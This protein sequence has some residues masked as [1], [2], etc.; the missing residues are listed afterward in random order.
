MK[1]NY[2]LVLVLNKVVFFNKQELHIPFRAKDKK[3]AKIKANGVIEIWGED[4]EIARLFHLM[5]V[6]SGSE[7]LFV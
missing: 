7:D 2:L 6:G 5:E 4:V 1:K 3:E